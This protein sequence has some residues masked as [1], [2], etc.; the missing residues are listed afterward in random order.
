MSRRL[1][2]KQ[3]RCSIATVGMLLMMATMAV[4]QS[5][6]GPESSVSVP[7]LVKFAGALKVDLGQTKTG[8][9]Q[10]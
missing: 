10:G 5:T 4:A 3:F 6:S 9:V 2:V 1:I 8:T 7:Q